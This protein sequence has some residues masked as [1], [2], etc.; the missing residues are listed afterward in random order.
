M[1]AQ[2]SWIQLHAL[3]AVPVLVAQRPQGGF[4]AY[5]RDWKVV[6]AGETAPD[7]LAAVE[8]AIQALLEDALTASRKAATGT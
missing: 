5:S 1:E 7:A 8:R 4:T 2:V 6:G 3:P